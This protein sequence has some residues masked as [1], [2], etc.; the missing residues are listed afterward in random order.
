[1]LRAKRIGRIKR[2]TQTGR[3]MMI[4][5]T[6]HDVGMGEEMEECGP[7][8]FLSVHL[9]VTAEAKITYEALATIATKLHHL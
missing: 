2:A 5:S 6:K 7:L 3:G 9:I 8:S 1:M 4:V